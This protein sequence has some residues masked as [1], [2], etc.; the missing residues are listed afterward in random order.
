MHLGEGQQVLSNPF[1]LCPLRP[2]Y[3][4]C[5]TWMYHALT[6]TRPTLLIR[7]QV[8][9]CTTQVDHTNERRILTRRTRETSFKPLLDRSAKGTVFTIIR[10]AFHPFNMYFIVLPYRR[11]SEYGATTFTN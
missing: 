5:S 10:K 6:V 1:L 7:Y 8:H 4:L 2:T 3:P 9:I 11:R